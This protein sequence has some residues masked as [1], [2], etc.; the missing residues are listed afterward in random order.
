LNALIEDR[1]QELKEY[2][3]RLSV[4]VFYSSTY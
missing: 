3:P 2:R 4:D 1:V